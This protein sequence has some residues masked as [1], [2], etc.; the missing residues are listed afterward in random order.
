MR[1]HRAAHCFTETLFTKVARNVSRHPDLPRSHLY[2]FGYG[3][4][5]ENFDAEASTATYGLCWGKDLL[6]ATLTVCFLCNVMCSKYLQFVQQQRFGF[7]TKEVP[8]DDDDDSE[9]DRGSLGTLIFETYSTVHL[10]FHEIFVISDLDM[11][12]VDQSGK[13]VWSSWLAQMQWRLA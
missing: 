5:G 7:W 9:S 12:H 10:K 4:H 11:E 6:C 13:F 3:W 1:F 8:L 2:Y